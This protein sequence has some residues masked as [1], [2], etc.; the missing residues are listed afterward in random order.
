VHWFNHQR[1]FEATGNVPAAEFETSYYQATN[2][3]AMAA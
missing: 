3:L 1:L 2:E